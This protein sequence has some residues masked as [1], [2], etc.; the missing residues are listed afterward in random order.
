MGMKDQVLVT[1][2]TETVSFWD[3]ARKSP[4]TY[5]HDKQLGLDKP[6]SFRFLYGGRIGVAL[7][8]IILA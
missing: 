1:D 7:S 8:D 2:R 3:D 5:E 4:A 6:F